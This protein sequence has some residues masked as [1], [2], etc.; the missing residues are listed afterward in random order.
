[1]GRF[2]FPGLPA[3][4]LLMIAGIVRAVSFLAT[5]V[6]TIT[7]RGQLSTRISQFT[8]IAMLVLALVALFGYLQ[9][10][11]A[12]PRTFATTEPIPNPIQA[13]FD[14]F[15][16]LQGYNLSTTTLRPG[17]PLDIDLYWQVTGQPPG[18]YILFIH[19]TNGLDLLVSQRDTHPGLGNF[20]SSEWRPGDRFVDSIRIYLPETAYAPTPSPSRWASMPLR[21][22]VWV[23]L[24]LMGKVWAT[25]WC[26]EPSAWNLPLAIR[27][28]PN[29]TTGLRQNRLLQ[30]D[31][32]LIITF[33]CHRCGSPCP[34][35]PF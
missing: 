29:E 12:R 20:P 33:C 15:A 6:P 24:G 10:A 17:E 4:V 14:F 22:T 2:F 18:N 32:G 8:I 28:I 26:W 23:L 1:M 11:Y 13:Q 34:N 5:L 27:P 19:L 16:N 21:G 30:M 3:L 31:I 35:E 7:P 9:P 25:T